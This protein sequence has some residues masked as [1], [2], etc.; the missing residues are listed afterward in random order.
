LRPLSQVPE[1]RLQTS[2]H[3]GLFWVLD[4]DTAVEESEHILHQMNSTPYADLWQMNTPLS[5]PLLYE[6]SK[7]GTSYANVK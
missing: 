3:D 1:A 4:E 5:I 6:P 2:M 7:I